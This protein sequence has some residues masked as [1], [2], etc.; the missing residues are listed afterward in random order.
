MKNIFLL[1]FFLFLF[2]SNLESQLRT[3]KNYNH[4]DGLDFSSINTALQTK[5]GLIW[6]GTSNSGLIN[7]DGK[8]FKEINFPKSDNKHWVNSIANTDLDEIYFSSK[9]KGFYKL[10]KNSYQLIYKNYR[11]TKE[12]LG[13]YAFEKSLLF[14]CDK[15]IH[16]YKNGRIVFEKVLTLNNKNLKITQF[17]ETPSGAILL[18]NIGGFFISK[19]ENSIKPLNVF[20]K[21]KPE[22]V[23]NFR[24]GF[25]SNHKIVFFNQNCDVISEVI[26]T[27]KGEAWSSINQNIVSPL[28]KG[29]KISTTTFDKKNN[30]FILTSKN[31]NLF[32]YK[33]NKIH[34]IISNC[35]E[36]PVGCQNSFIDFYSSIWLCSSLKGLYKISIEPFTKIELDPVYK[37]TLITMCF[38][39]KKGD[40]IIGSEGGQTNISINN[41]SKFTANNFTSYSACKLKDIVYIGTSE[42]LKQYDTRTKRISNVLI[43]EIANKKIPFL[44]SDESTVWIGVENEGLYRYDPNNNSITICQNLYSGFPKNFYTAQLSFDR[45]FILFGSDNGIHQFD[46]K[47][48]TFFHINDFP[49][50]LKLGDVSYLSVV[51]KFQTRWFT[52]ENGLVG[53]TKNNLKRVIQDKKKFI[54]TD[55]HTLNSDN[56]GNLIIGTNKGITIFNINKLGNVLKFDNYNGKSGFTGYETRFHS[57]FQDENS[58]YLGTAEGLYIVNTSVLQFMSKPTSPQI[59]MSKVLNNSATQSYTY[60]YK[61]KVNNPKI[62]NIL[63]S[64]RLLGKI[65]SWSEWRRKDYVLFNDLSDNEYLFQV[66][67]TLDG[68]NFSKITSSKLKVEKPFWTSDTFIFLIIALFLTLNI[69]FLNK[70]KSFDVKTIFS[71]KDNTITT[72]LIPRIIL[73]GSIVNI[74]AHIVGHELDKSIPFYPKI[75]SI[76]SFLLGVIYLLSIKSSKINNKNLTKILLVLGISVVLF[77]NFTELYLSKL[78]FYFILIVSIIST[79]IPFV[80]EKLRSSIAYSIAILA[81]SC[82]CFVLLDEVNFNKYLFIIIL[83]LIVSIAIFTTYL[84]H[85]SI[86]KLLFISGVINKGDVLAI[87]IDGS[88][89]MIYV[90]ENI[91]DF[92]NSSHEKLL[93]E[94]ISKLTDFLPNNSDSNIF[95]TDK[96]EDGKKYLSP[97]ISNDNLIIWIEWSCKI[98]SEDVK[99]ILGQ[100]VTVRMELETTFELLVQN[101]EDFIYQCDASGNFIFL[102]KQALF[103]I[104]YDK[105]ELIGVNFSNVIEEKNKMEV[106]SHYYKHYKSLQ[107][108][109]YFEF[110]IVTKRGLKIWLGQ[111][112]TTLYEPG[113]K[114]RIKGF[115]AVARDITEK[116]KQ[117]KIIEEQQNDITSSIHYAKRIQINL[118]P[119]TEKFDSYFKESFLLFKPKD[120]V[121]GDFYWMEKVNEY[122]V[123]AVADCTGHGV[124]GSFMTLLGIN[125]LNSIVL[126]NQLTEPGKILDEL[127]KKLVHVLP[128]G[129]GDAKVND[130]MEITI[131][132][133]NHDTNEM[134]YACAGSRFMICNGDFFEIFKGDSKHIGDYRNQ[135]A[136]YSEFNIVLRENDTIY[137]LTDGLQDQFG[138]LRNKKFNFKRIREIIKEIN[139]LPLKDQKLK[140]ETNFSDW[141]DTYDQTDDVTIIGIRGLVS[142]SN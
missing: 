89:K 51:D 10:E 1:L 43:S 42:G 130:G 17:F 120:I 24:Y 123:L 141:M 19:S 137:L 55:F 40:F 16:L 14:V 26:L 35:S 114:D 57:Q 12:Y 128:R 28:L 112:V 45:N 31:G 62:H 142:Q 125:L 116:R 100:N 140:L 44:F 11:H 22:E 90:S 20:L 2:S 73:V 96:F 85:D 33:K 127:D 82:L 25:F 129:K 74:V 69:Y 72:R 60:E 78:H 81:I 39:S 115:L 87:A 102:N 80:F 94:N 29:D 109:S 136:R 61:Y 84:R 113:S 121:S 95:S 108:S 98:Y 99:V 103:K 3:F 66:R 83:I 4:K 23:S 117:E 110:P 139:D 76:T 21:T 15:S 107:D 52:L 18:T 119:N 68:K 75:I 67:S 41:F 118:L 30:E 53:F 64:Y 92:I 70:I 111:H 105:D 97:I 79:L 13:V 47:S 27:S 36:K 104:G 56:Y 124:P 101:A 8:D 46:L 134:K 131:C 88:G 138:G 135:N 77:E 5:K 122:T 50:K 9:F 49:S 106:I 71:N 58:I 32:S 37:N 132:V 6:L 133:F 54:S 126:E 86:S 7:F 93:N 48:K 34:Q 65:N 38:K 91:S 63:Y 59:E